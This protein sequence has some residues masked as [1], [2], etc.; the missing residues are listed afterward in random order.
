MFKKTFLILICLFISNQTGFAK[1]IPVKIAPKQVITTKNDATDVGDW[2]KFKVVKD[3]Y[4]DD[5]K[6]ILKKDDELVGT[7]DFVHPNGWVGDAAEIKLKHFTHHT[8]E[9]KITYEYPVSIKGKPSQHN[10]MKRF[11][12]TISTAIRGSEVFVEADSDDYN[13][14]IDN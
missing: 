14:F 7:V 13:I 1:Q 3:V 6:L 5:N 2:V 4:N 8:K 10:K 11:F 9:K 12:E